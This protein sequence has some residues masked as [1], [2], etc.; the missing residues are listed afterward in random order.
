MKRQSKATATH[1]KELYKAGL[2]KTQNSTLTTFFHPK[3]IFF[4]FLFVLLGFAAKGEATLFAVLLWKNWDKFYFFSE[5][6]NEGNV[7]I[8][9]E[10]VSEVN[11]FSENIPNNEDLD[12]LESHSMKDLPYFICSSL[13]VSNTIFLGVGGF[14][15][16]YFYIRQRDTP[17]NWK[18]QPKRFLTEEN[19][20]HEFW[21]GECC[22]IL[23]AAVSGVASCYVANTGYHSK[24]YFDINDYGWIYFLLSTILLFLIQDAM[25]YYYHRMLHWPIF[26]KSFHK[27]H[28]RYHSPTAWSA[29]AMHPVESLVF[30]ILLLIPMLIIPFHFVSV[31]VLFHYLFFYGLVDHS[32]IDM[33]SI[34]P[35]QPPVRFHDD[36]HKYF[37]VN[38]GFNTMMFDRFHDTLRKTSRQ[39]GE[40]IFYGRGAEKKVE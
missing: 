29:V 33:D 7:S 8:G 1:E 36:H 18:C 5:K 37:H 3:S 31:A 25:S 21:L 40:D 14:L 26:Y 4:G 12:F 38:F 20:R 2:H 10:N 23:N 13:V 6:S 11:T 16:W 28:H 34:W 9:S 39:Y 24:V 19:E 17:E 35:W 15:H 30:E 22:L 32:G 27:W